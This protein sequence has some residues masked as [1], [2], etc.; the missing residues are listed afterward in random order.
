LLVP[1][2]SFLSAGGKWDRVF[3]AAAVTTMAAAIAAKFILAPMRKRFIN[4]ANA[5]AKIVKND[6]ALN[7]KKEV[8]TAS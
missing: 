2:A 4:N 8:E 6:I 1:L 7:N 3:I 5:N